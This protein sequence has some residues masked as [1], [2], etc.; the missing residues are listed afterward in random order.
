MIKGIIFD[1]DGTLFDFNATWGAWT[2][3]M[4]I[5][6]AGARADEM[7]DLLGYDMAAAVFRPGSIVI[8]ET[9]DV[10]ADAMLS[11][12][13]DTTKHDLIMRLGDASKHVPQIAAAP[14]RPVLAD[15]RAMGL[16][17]GVA[18]NDTETAARANLADVADLFDFIAGCDSGYGCKP[19]AGQLHGFCAA[20]GLDPAGCAMVGDS[21]HDLHAGRAAGMTCI[22][23]LTGPAPRSAL[24]AHADVV[25]ASIGDLGAWIS[26]QAQ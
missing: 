4:I 9:T 20:T 11:L 1:K 26:A 23:V 7:A 12:L 17:L 25:L 22:G 6:E 13:P 8:A 21:L 14:L 10:V 16:V 18:T 19:A 3:N 15:L 24:A 5:S 2:R